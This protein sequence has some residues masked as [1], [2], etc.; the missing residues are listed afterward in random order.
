MLHLPTM[1]SS[2]F[3]SGL[4]CAA[5]IEEMKEADDQQSRDVSL[6]GRTKHEDTSTKDQIHCD[7]TSRTVACGRLCVGS[8]CAKIAADAI[9]TSPT[10][11]KRP[12]EGGERIEVVRG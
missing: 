11:T 2:F 9:V 5:V 4:A 10:Q 3:W 1:T 12:A 6:H 7:S 8:S